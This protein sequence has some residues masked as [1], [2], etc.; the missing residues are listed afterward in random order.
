MGRACEQV[1]QRFQ[2][3]GPMEGTK[4]TEVS[5]GLG[6]V[7]RPSQPKDGSNRSLQGPRPKGSLIPSHTFRE[8]STMTEHGPGVPGGVRLAL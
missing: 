6:R 3:S 7:R 8:L 1:G 2:S 4:A 5:P